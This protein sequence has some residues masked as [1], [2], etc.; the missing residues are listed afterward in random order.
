MATLSESEF[1]GL[2]KSNVIDA[3]GI[4][5]ETGFAV[6]TITDSWD[7]SDEHAHLLALQNKLNAYFAFIET[8]EIYESYP[9]A[10]GRNI[11]IDVISRFPL[12][13]KGKKLL[14]LASE[15][16]RSLNVSIREFCY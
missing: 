12:S 10:K 13:R 3:A 2:D 8:G 9:E 5:K 1:M 6:L 15:S 14:E 16:S 4:E 11:R 7:W